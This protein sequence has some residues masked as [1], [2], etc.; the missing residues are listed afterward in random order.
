MPIV[1]VE[2]VLSDGVAPPPAL[3]HCLTD[4][5]A[6]VLARDAAPVHVLVSP[7]GGGRQAFGG[8]LVA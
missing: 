4:A 2:R 6:A 8:R 1:D 5:I 3:A 7:A